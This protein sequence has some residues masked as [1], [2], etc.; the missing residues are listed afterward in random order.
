MSPCVPQ[1]GL[2]ALANFADK[3]PGFADNVYMNPVKLGLVVRV[4]RL[5]EA[6]E[7]AEKLL[8]KAVVRGDT[9]GLLGVSSALCNESTRGHADLAALAVK[10]AEA[11]YEIDPEH[12]GGLVK[13]LEA[14]VFAGDQAKVKE[15][16][17]K[18][19]AAAKAEVRVPTTRSA[20]WE[21]RL[22]TSPP[23]TKSRPKRSPR[24]RSTWSPRKR[25]ACG[26]TSR[27]GPRSTGCGPRVP[28]PRAITRAVSQLNFGVGELR[29][30]EQAGGNKEVPMQKR[31]IVRLTDEVRNEL[32]G[33][34]KKL[35]GTDEKE[36][37]RGLASVS[38][39]RSCRYPPDGNERAIK[40]MLQDQRG[41]HARS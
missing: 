35:K 8:V 20:R 30:F 39:F 32:R 4:K 29:G 3:W 36:G 5:A 22:H 34:V 12:R 14:Y 37:L 21:L 17:P 24:R 33:V 27:N 1:S 23:A 40:V 18:A 15:L 9:S 28:K 2:D 10:A 13:L 19:V 25:S 38:S 31:Y 41:T 11:S 6:K 16:G 26:G 7:L